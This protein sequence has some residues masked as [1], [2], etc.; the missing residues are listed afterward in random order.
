MKSA[1]VVAEEATGT[2][3][4]GIHVF[5]ILELSKNR[6]GGGSP[7]AGFEA[8]LAPLIH[9][10]AATGRILEVGGGRSPLGPGMGVSNSQLTVN[11]VSQKELDFLPSDTTTALFD[12]AQPSHIPA[13]LH[14][15]FDLIYSR[16]VFEHV[17]SVESAMQST[18]ALLR[19]GGK[20]IHFFPTLFATPFV[21]N[22]ILP[23]DATRSL[24]KFLIGDSYERFPA[25]YAGTWITRKNVERWERIGFRRVAPIQFFGHS[26]FRR[27]PPISKAAARFN[28][29]AE[30]R[31]MSALGAFVYLCVEK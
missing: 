22:R 19:P 29:L 6:L 1:E 2:S 4:A 25:H 17:S 9:D 30:D 16:S 26:Y 28:Q 11:D 7:F 18:H 10:V 21:V 23:F 3:N 13:D 8:A 12:I 14:G 15:Q 20:A 31:K 5:D 24:V 27:F